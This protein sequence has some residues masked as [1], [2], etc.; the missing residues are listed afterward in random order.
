M[1]LTVLSVAYPLASVGPDAVGGAEQILGAIDGALVAAGHRSI[2]VARADSQVAGTLVPVPVIE[3]PFDVAKGLA[4]WEPHRAAIRAAL[5]RFPVDIV[6][7]HGVDFHGYLPPLGPPVLATLHLPPAWYPHRAFFPERPDTWLNPVSVAQARACPPSPNLLDPIENGVPVE[8]LQA[9]HAKRR[10]AVFLGRICPEKGVTEAIDAAKR[11]DMPLLVAGEV[12]P[13]DF[14][15]R[16]FADEVRPRL[17]SLRR[18]IGPAGFA[19]KRRLLT[20]ARCVLVPSLVPE[21][22]SLVAREALACGTPVIA[23][24]NG[25]LPETIE[26]GTT[27]FLVRDVDEM[28]DAIRACDA[29]DPESCRRT[30]RERFSLEGMTD[31]YLDLYGR[32][33][34]AAHPWP[35]MHAPGARRHPIPLPPGEGARSG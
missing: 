2:V 14:H 24:P 22:S 23:F 5:D 35:T 28:A 6:H 11:A 15:E 29:I 25:A 12:Y 32:L 31:R 34:R 9:R 10:F 3:G 13:Y 8:A 17:D 30:A 21:T 19:R 33:A 26:H 18:F 1:T 27:G 16:Y 4:S 20:A 7:L